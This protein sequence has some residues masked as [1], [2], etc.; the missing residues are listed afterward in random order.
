MTRPDDA[1]DVAGIVAAT[2]GCAIHFAVLPENEAAFLAYLN[3]TRGEDEQIPPWLLRKLMSM[4]HGIVAPD[5]D[6]QLGVE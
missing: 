4:V 1:S 3:L 2:A 5:C 6:V